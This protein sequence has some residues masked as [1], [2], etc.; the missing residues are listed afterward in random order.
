MI[1][2][3]TSTLLQSIMTTRLTTEVWLRVLRKSSYGAIIEPP[4]EEMSRCLLKTSDQISPSKR[5]KIKLDS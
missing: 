5:W 1:L 2:V 3:S 4:N